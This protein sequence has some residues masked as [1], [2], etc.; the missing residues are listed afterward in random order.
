MP[1]MHSICEKPQFLKLIKDTFWLT[2]RIYTLGVRCLLL[3]LRLFLQLLLSRLVPLVS[4][5]L[6]PVV[7]LFYLV[8]SV[9]DDWKCLPHF[10]V[11]HV[12]LVVQFI[13]KLDQFVNFLFFSIFLLFFGCGP[14]RFLLLTR[15][16]WLHSACSLSL[17]NLLFDLWFFCFFGFWK[18]HLQTLVF[19]LIFMSLN[20]PSY[21]FSLF[22][23]IFSK[24]F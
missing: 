19:L 6:L 10:V 14:C 1:W 12:F 18:F 20:F 11:F 17:F 13:C 3:Q 4:Y 15:F 22:L 24:F 21:F 23:C 9:L 2:V 16:F 5:G 8:H 7:V